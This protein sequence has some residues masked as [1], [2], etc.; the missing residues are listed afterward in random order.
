VG[1][2][3][4]TDLFMMT[5]ERAL[6]PENIE[7]IR[8][9]VEDPIVVDAV[10]TEGGWFERFLETM[11][12][13]L[14]SD[15]AM[16]VAAWQLVDRTVFEV[17]AVDAGETIE[18]RDIATGDR[19][20][21]RERTLSCTV[22]VGSLLCARAVP[23]GETTQFIGGIFPVAQGREADV[24]ALCERKDGAELCRWVRDLHAPPTFTTREG[25]MFVHCTARVWATGAAT[26][27][28][29]L[30]A[31]YERDGDTWNELVDIGDGERIVRGRLTLVA[32]AIEVSTTSEERMERTL[33]TLFEFLPG[34]TV[35]S[36]ERK[37]FRPGDWPP[38]AADAGGLQPL[39]LSEPQREE[40]LQM[41]EERWMSEPVPALGGVTP[42]DAV[43]DPTRRE[44]V[45]RLLA[46][47]PEAHEEAVLTLRP[48]RIRAELGL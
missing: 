31:H 17:V 10:L 3:A 21:V 15:E 34:A 26:A 8:E 28:A 41:M 46:S 43:A 13:V 22:R 9:A 30:D 2:D 35:V 36:D 4:A 16:L 40:L 25:E 45:R 24:L 27:R 23:D 33:A 42:R 5:H 1:G 47:F 29:V 11:R 39:Q 32:D 20:T 37:P 12:D 14:P 48:S 7:S 6:D 18:V 38:T 44:S 19:L